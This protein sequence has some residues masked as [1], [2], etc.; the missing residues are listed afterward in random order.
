MNIKTEQRFVIHY[1]NVELH[2]VMSMV[3]CSLSKA[4]ALWLLGGWAGVHHFYLGRH[5]QGVVW[6]TTGSMLGMG[7]LRDAFR[8]SDYVR[9]ANAEPEHEQY[10]VTY[11]RLA[12]VPLLNG[13]LMI[14]MAMLG[15]WYYYVVGGM[16]AFIFPEKYI[17]MAY[18][19]G[20]FAMSAGVWAAGSCGRAA[21]SLNHILFMVITVS[22]AV[23]DLQLATP[24]FSLPAAILAAVCTRRWRVDRDDCALTFYAA[25]VTLAVIGVFAVV[26][27]CFVI[28]WGLDKAYLTRDAGGNI[29]LNLKVLMERAKNVLDGLFNGLGGLFEVIGYMVIKW[30]GKD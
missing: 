27:A 15:T 23:S 16:A 2:K 26:S 10:L 22:G 4:Y 1:F 28:L 12:P 25:V 20:A 7:W 3:R 30:L 18:I 9:Q 17:A 11:M 5:V 21:C 13:S 24:L 6:V 14:G 19:V 29:I 8:I